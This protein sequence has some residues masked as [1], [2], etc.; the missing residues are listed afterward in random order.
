MTR[1]EKIEKAARAVLEAIQQQHPKREGPRHSDMEM[2]EEEWCLVD[3]LRSAL[4]EPAPPPEVKPTGE[5]E[6]CVTC[7]GAGCM[8]VL[9]EFADDDRTEVC[10]RCH[11]YGKTP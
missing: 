7:G 3:A 1:A 5:G 4:A 11:G 10:P 8:N 6:R 2:G 9:G